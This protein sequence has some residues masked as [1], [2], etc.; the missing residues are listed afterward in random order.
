MTS[1]PDFSLRPRH[2]IRRRIAAAFVLVGCL[3][4]STAVGVIV[5]LHRV[6]IDARR[7][8]EEDRE[9]KLAFSMLAKLEPLQEVASQDGREALALEVAGEA[10][11]R[12]TE[13]E[14]GHRAG[15]PSEAGHQAAEDRIAGELEEALDQLERFGR[16]E[17]LLS[18]GEKVKLVGLTLAWAAQIEKETANEAAR[19][20]ADLDERIDGL[21]WA[22]VATPLLVG[23]ILGALYWL[24]ERWVVRPLDVLRRGA[25]RL[26]K[27]ELDHRITLRTRDELGELAL[28]F[29]LMAERLA[30]MQRT[31]EAR[32]RDRTREFIEA[33]RLADLGTFAAGIAHEVNTPLA[34]IASCAEGLERRVKAGTA[35]REEEL[36]YLGTITREAYRAHDIASRLLAFARKDP[37]P[38]SLIRLDETVNQAARLLQHQLD[39]KGITLELDLDGTDV[40]V[41]ANPAEMEQALLNVLKNAIDASPRDGT[42][43]V[44]CRAGEDRVSIA[45]EDQGPGVAPRDRTRIFDPFFTTKPVGKGTG[46]GLSLAY[47]IL[48]TYGGKI[49][50]RDAPAGGASFE[51]ALP[52]ASAGSIE[53]A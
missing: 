48:E 30:S 20:M 43:T 28:E 21:V 46:L 29:N 5:N 12:L 3:L 47:R 50:V 1:P 52:R 45:I 53:V 35:S 16:G 8:R 27:G 51:I 44:R 33:A 6:S 11:A 40:L 25:E 26:G 22:M 49:E 39:S 36:D 38:T 37:G 24:L 4:T 9:A 13:M 7:F 14:Q 23:A 42:V 19:S 2:G 32:V 31:L 15:D 41:E 10:R 18:R 17:L 34:S